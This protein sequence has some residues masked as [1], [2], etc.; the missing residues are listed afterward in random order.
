MAIK[1]LRAR[2]THNANKGIGL[3]LSGKPEKNISSHS[4]RISLWGKFHDSSSQTGYGRVAGI[5]IFRDD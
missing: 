5:S 3:T 1:N 4:L 2:L